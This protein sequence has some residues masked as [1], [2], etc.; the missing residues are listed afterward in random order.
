[1]NP[2]PRTKNRY[3]K[4]SV[5]DAIVNYLTAQPNKTADTTAIARAINN[6]RN[7]T[8]T[9]LRYHANNKVVICKRK[10]TNGCHAQPAVW[11]LPK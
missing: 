10:A 7:G 11:R 9:L 3:R 4:N 1:V 2:Y 6:N 5:R 8:A